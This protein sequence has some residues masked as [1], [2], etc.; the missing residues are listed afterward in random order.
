MAGTAFADLN[1][2]QQSLVLKTLGYIRYNGQVWF[3]KDTQAFRITFIQ[4][5]VSK[6]SLGV[7]TT[8]TT[9]FDYRNSTTPWTIVKPPA[10]DAH[11]SGDLTQAQKDAGGANWLRV[12]YLT[13]LFQGKSQRLAEPR[14]RHDNVH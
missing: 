12:V 6:D 8:L 5:E 11:F 9:P 7:Y 2:E 4:G 1:L 3:N 10:A 13:G 14:S